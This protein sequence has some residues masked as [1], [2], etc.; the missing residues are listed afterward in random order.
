MTFHA[1]G[2]TGRLFSGERHE[3]GAV[4]WHQVGT[5]PMK[6]PLAEGWTE[7]KAALRQDRH[8]GPAAPP[9][10]LSSIAQPGGYQPVSHT[11]PSFLLVLPQ[12]PNR[13]SW[14]R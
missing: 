7:Q 6:L 10:G 3:T 4:R 5:E 11:V 12:T 1:P 2:L 8:T 9:R 14:S 13:W